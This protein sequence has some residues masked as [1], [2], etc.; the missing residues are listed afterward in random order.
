MEREPRKLSEE[1]RAT[2]LGNVPGRWRVVPAESWAV[3]SGG[4]FR[5]RQAVA[6]VVRFLYS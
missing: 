4:V 5:N 3:V 2:T 6:H 1:T